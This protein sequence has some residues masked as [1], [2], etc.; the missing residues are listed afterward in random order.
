VAG[1]LYG[2]HRSRAHRWT[3]D[4]LPVLEKT[5]GQKRVLPE[6]QIH[7]VEAFFHR[8]PTAQTLFVDGSERPTQ[9]PQDS[10][11]QKSYYSGKKNDPPVSTSS[12]AMI[13]GVFWPFLPR[14]PAL[15]MTMRCSKTGSLPTGSP[16][17]SS[18]GPIPVFKGYVP[19]ILS[20]RLS[21]R[22]KN[23]EAKNSTLWINGATRYG[24]GFASSSN[25]PLVE[26]ELLKLVEDILEPMGIALKSVTESFVDTSSPEGKAMFQMLGSFSE[27]D[28]NQLIRKLRAGR[29]EKHAHGGFSVGQVATGFNSVD[30]KLVVVDEW[31]S[32]VKRIYRMALQ[33][34]G[35]NRIART[36]NEEGVT[37]K[38]SCRF[39][40]RTV[41]LILENRTYTGVVK[42]R[43]QE[44]GVHEAIISPSMFGR[45]QRVL[46]RA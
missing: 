11:E 3:Q 21:N 44:K 46:Q 23:H 14:P 30:G 8:F 1:V 41:K 33:G 34:D 29:L 25:T 7:Q 38:N 24:L 16:T 45:V 31:A 6:R 32:I 43:S 15:I 37:T 27:L 28:K 12:S 22:R 17:A 10:T 26:S 5:L 2:V 35:V 4:W 39:Y 40:A 36:L 18:T 13:N 9:R 42:N 20:V 19:T